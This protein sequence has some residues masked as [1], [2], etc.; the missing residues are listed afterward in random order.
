MASFPAWIGK[1]TWRELTLE[2]NAP[3]GQEFTVRR[4]FS[5]R[6][7]RYLCDGATVAVPRRAM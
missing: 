7:P 1:R 4:R 5:Q 3:R 6:L 2:S